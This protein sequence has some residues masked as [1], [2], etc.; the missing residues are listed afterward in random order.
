M[1]QQ[2]EQRSKAWEA[3]SI[4]VRTPFFFSLYCFGR[5]LVFAINSFVGVLQ[6]AAEMAQEKALDLEAIAHDCKREGDKTLAALGV[7]IFRS[8]S[9]S[10]VPLS[11]PVPAARSP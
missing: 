4:K 2:V 10:T 8:P 1:K 3:L 9:S 6:S 11:P 7:R 5:Y